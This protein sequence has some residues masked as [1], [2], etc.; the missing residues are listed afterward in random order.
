MAHFE[1]HHFYDF[2]HAIENYL[3]SR[4]LQGAD[5]FLKVSI[6]VGCLFRV[7][8]RV[9]PQFITFW[10]LAWRGFEFCT[11][12]PQ[13]WTLEQFLELKDDLH[14]SDTCNSDTNGWRYSLK[15]RPLHPTF[16][17]EIASPPAGIRRRRREGPERGRVSDMVLP[18]SI[19]QLL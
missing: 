4:T 16:F 15:D 19:V 11:F 10:H 1:S 3:A 13:Q 12:G 17:A 5:Y 14:W 6:R 18:G 9:K 7:D 8:L 2:P